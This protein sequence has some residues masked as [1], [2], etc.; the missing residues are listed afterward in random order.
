MDSNIQQ[1]KM[2]GI[3]INAMRGEG[4]GDIP[5]ILLEEYFNKKNLVVDMTTF[6]PD[7][8]SRSDPILVE[9]LESNREH[10]YYV[11]FIPQWTP[12]LIMY[13]EPQGEIFVSLHT[14]NFKEAEVIVSDTTAM[15]DS[16]LELK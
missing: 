7:T 10:G 12:Y 5:K 15:F 11:V 4:L 14:D 2:V 6:R 8:L 13:V 3:I 1:P 9:I 16:C